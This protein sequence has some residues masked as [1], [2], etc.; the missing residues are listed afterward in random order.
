[1]Y[2]IVQA[3]S[4]CLH[5]F[6]TN[7]FTCSRLACVWKSR[8]SLSHEPR[9]STRFYYDLFRTVFYR[10]VRTVFFVQTFLSKVGKFISYT[11]L[12]G[13]FL[14]FQRN[15][16]PPTMVIIANVVDR[17]RVARTT[18]TIGHGF[19]TLEKPC[20]RTQILFDLLAAFRLRLSSR[21]PRKQS[22]D[23]PTRGVRAR[24]S[25][26]ALSFPPPP[27]FSST[28]THTAVHFHAAC[29]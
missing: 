4:V 13:F 15:G 6:R 20:N 3:V 22:C 8:H 19:Y 12:R 23:R 26:S 21:R 5:E 2:D 25:T 24:A 7:K 11:Q 27:F 9:T 10:Y 1:M 28:T 17:N 16:V 18:T 29:P 14:R